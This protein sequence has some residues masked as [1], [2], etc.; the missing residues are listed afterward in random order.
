M[1]VPT[2]VDNRLIFVIPWQDHI[3]VGTTDTIYDGDL[4]APRA[5]RQDVA[6]LL[7]ALNYSFPGVSLTFEDVISVQAGLRPLLSFGSKSTAQAS[8][9]DR[10]FETDDGIIAIGGGKLT[11]YRKMASS[12]VNLAVKRLV[13]AG[14]LDREVPCPTASISLLGP[15]EGENPTESVSELAAR[16]IPRVSTEVARHL[17]SQYGT[18]ALDLIE[19]AEQDDLG[20]RISPNSPV[21]RAEVV[22]AARHEM[23]EAIGDV[24]ARRTRLALVERGQA[25]H[26][27]PTVAELMG[28]ELGWSESERLAQIQ[29]YELEAEQFAIAL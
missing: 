10:V 6:Y 21:L 11:T 20:T 4:D 24:L 9:K 28:R 23:A 25:R 29:A 5:T 13:R 3:L 22:Y 18:G 17:I 12:V 8:R 27:A 26:L 19:L 1:Y 7:D 2:G 14:I 16:L 15:T